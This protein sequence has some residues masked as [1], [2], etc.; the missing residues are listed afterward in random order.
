[1]EIIY[2]QIIHLFVDWFLCNHYPYLEIFSKWDLTYK[3]F[4]MQLNFY[5]Y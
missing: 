2:L 5:E 3:F 1:M 4:Q